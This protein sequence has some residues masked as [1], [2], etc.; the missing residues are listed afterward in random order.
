MT[1]GRGF[2]VSLTIHIYLLKK[3]AFI[4]FFNSQTSRETFRKKKTSYKQTLI[5]NG[6]NQ[7]YVQPEDFPKLPLK[8]QKS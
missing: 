7:F 5:I 6:V 2:P 4:E 1:I 3:K 8:T